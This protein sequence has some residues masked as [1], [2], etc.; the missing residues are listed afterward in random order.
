MQRQINQMSLE[1]ISKEGC[2]PTNQCQPEHQIYKL[3]K[4]LPTKFGKSLGVDFLTS[5]TSLFYP[6]LCYCILLRF[7]LVAKMM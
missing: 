3:R 4:E 7:I 6:V 2:S 1:N 5:T